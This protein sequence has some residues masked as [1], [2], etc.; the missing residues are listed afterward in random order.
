MCFYDSEVVLICLLRS[1][2]LR[3]KCLCK[4]QCLSLLFT[5]PVLTFLCSSPC[6][7]ICHSKNIVSLHSSIDSTVAWN[8]FSKLGCLVLWR[9]NPKENMNSVFIWL[10]LFTCYCFEVWVAKSKKCLFILL[11]LWILNNFIALS[12]VNPK[13]LVHCAWWNWLL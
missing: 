13:E 8:R 12:G 2:V 4:F 9:F 7:S 11:E 10:F 5:Y 1:L 6:L 3:N